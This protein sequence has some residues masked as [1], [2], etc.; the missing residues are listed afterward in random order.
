MERNILVAPDGQYY[1]DGE[2]YGAEVYLA[3]GLDGSNYYLID[4][5]EV[6]NFEPATKEDYL[7][8]LERLG[9]SHE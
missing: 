9:V 5:S 6:V 8:A 7:Y 2:T 1:T 4:K 3:E